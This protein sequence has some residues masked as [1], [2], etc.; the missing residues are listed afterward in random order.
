MWLKKFRLGR[1]ESLANDKKDETSVVT[2]QNA[3]CL[4]S[5][6]VQK[7]HASKRSKIIQFSSII[8]ILITIFACDVFFMVNQQSTAN[9][10]VVA[11]ASNAL[12]TKSVLTP[13]QEKDKNI[14]VMAQDI[15]D[16]SSPGAKVILVSSSSN[17]IASD[18]A[19]TYGDKV[20]AT[21]VVF[22]ITKNGSATTVSI[23]VIIPAKKTLTAPDPQKKSASPFTVLN[24]TDTDNT[25]SKTI[26]LYV[27]TNGDD[28]NIGSFDKPFKTIQKAV[29]TASAG[30]TV[31]IRGGTYYGYVFMN[32]SGTSSAPIKIT[33]YPNESVTLD[34]NGVDTS[35]IW[36]SLFSLNSQSNIIVD[37]LRIINSKGFGIG[38]IGDLG[39]G[40]YLSDNIIIQNCTTEDTGQGG[41]VLKATNVKILHNT[42]INANTTKWDTPTWQPSKY[43]EAMCLVLIN[44]FEVAYN[45]VINAGK[46]GVDIHNGSNHGSVHHNYIHGSGINRQYPSAP[47][48]YIDGYAKTNTDIDVYSNTVAGTGTRGSGIMVACENGGIVQNVRIHHNV[49]YN[50][51]DFGIGVGHWGSNPGQIRDIYIYNNTTYNNGNG[52]SSD[53]GGGF[54]STHDGIVSNIVVANNIFSESN[55]SPLYTPL[56]A[57]MNVNLNDHG[58]YVY[59]NLISKDGGDNHYHGTEGIIANPLFADPSNGNFSLQASSPAKNAGKSVTGINSGGGAFNI[60]AF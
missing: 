3:N 54:F 4:D 29:D 32:K 27:A 40:T 49:S 37:G 15:S 25:S 53:G 38:N 31:Y 34:G 43:D 45:N 1:N 21:T 22:K 42:I 19:I 36:G 33:N 17:Q 51:Y 23:T 8:I 9:T 11:E 14:V 24:N 55:P 60:G 39:D 18:G 28:A 58:Y 46:E 52:V 10:K 35:K 12:K 30:Y 26:P 2:Y 16:K 44:N 41:I 13:I 20:V 56:Y 48:I 7:I 50:N 47:A 6:L 57:S 5:Q 59:N